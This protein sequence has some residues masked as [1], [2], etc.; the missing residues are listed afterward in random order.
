MSSPGETVRREQERPSLASWEA[1]EASVIRHDLVIDAFFR[2]SDQI[3]SVPEDPGPQARL[4]SGSSRSRRHPY[5]RRPSPRQSEGFFSG[6]VR[7]PGLVLLDARGVVLA[8][9]GFSA[10][11]A[12]MAAE[13]W[14]P[15][16]RVAPSVLAALPH[17][18]V[19]VPS[20]R[21]G[22][23]GPSGEGGEA[24][25]LVLVPGEGDGNSPL[26][27]ALLS[28]AEALLVKE[29]QLLQREN[30]RQEMAHSLRKL[31]AFREV[32]LATE[33]PSLSTAE[34][35]RGMLG[36]VRSMVGADRAMLA[37]A[38][39]VAL[40]GAGQ[41][42]SA[43]ASREGEIAR[44]P[45]LKRI[46]EE[47]LPVLVGRQDTKPEARE[48]LQRLGAQAALAVPVVFQDGTCVAAAL[49]ARDRPE[50][51]GARDVELLSF[52]SLQMGLALENAA[53]RD[54][55]RRRLDDL[56]TELGLAQRVQ[57]AILPGE[58]LVRPGVRMYG[59]SH[60]AR[61]V[62]G[63]FYDYW[64]AEDGACVGVLG[65]IMGKGVA[66]ALLMALLRAQVRSCAG[67]RPFGLPVLRRLGASTTADLRRAGAMAT[68]QLLRLEPHS[69]EL[70]WLV[71]GH[72]PPLLRRDGRWGLLEGP[73]GM[74]LGLLEDP[75]RERSVGRCTLK[76][77]DLVLLWSDGLLELAFPDRRAI[78]IEGVLDIV[79]DLA[80]ADAVEAVRLLEERLKATV[81]P[82]SSK[83]D[84]TVLA[85]SVPEHVE[86]GSPA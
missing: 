56:T 48:L 37:L 66:A 31:S 78:R 52:V 41:D 20:G 23:A 6:S 69:R 58:P 70:T 1:F 27:A 22:R 82:G 32:A 77:G 81:P 75:P 14:V 39:P 80:P 64:E 21:R 40:G 73:R 76:P 84:V 9:S 51:F 34:L 35:V 30:E 50:P 25:V 63:D 18:T 45:A 65:D 54:R 79:S 53:L 49:V 12:R 55:L 62:G 74:A 46:F 57:Q 59:F 33:A 43:P 11:L 38:D 17:R 44:L 5:G 13:G 28:A 67:E 60:P 4:R 71:A 47:R 3:L 10:A 83:D 2:M 15:G 19:T 24:A 8:R 29:A 42:L 72:H 86:E 36:V 85:L 7:S 61:H 16:A 68:L 26:T